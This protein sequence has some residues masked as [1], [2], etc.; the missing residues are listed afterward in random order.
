MK[1]VIATGIFPPEAGGP[2]YYAKELAEALR[3]KGIEAPVVTYGRLKRLPTGLRHL[4]YLL[5][6]APYALHA[7]AI[8]ALDTFSVGVPAVILGKILR[9][10]VTI[11]TGGDFLWESYLERTRH[12][13]PLPRFYEEHLPFTVRERLVFLLTRFV[14]Q[15]ASAV[16][17]STAMQRD[18]WVRVYGLAAERTHI[19]ANAVPSHELPTP[20]AHKDFLWHVRPIVMKNGARVHAAFEQARATHP[21]ISLEEGV[22]PKQQLLDRMRAC[23]AVILPSLTEISPNYILDALRFRKPFIMDKYSGLADELGPYGMLVDPLDTGDIARAIGELATEDGYA[24][25][26]ERVGAF[27]GERPYAQIADDFLSLIK[28][29]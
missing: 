13:L 9:V 17:F 20:P 2:A 16:A 22:I 5:R 15:H 21:D 4:A 6:L 12:E 1:L 11:R 18:L 28:T 19:I 26:L 24:R 29:L 3:E 27:S 14:L 25:A 23:Y 7:R 10:P 8:I